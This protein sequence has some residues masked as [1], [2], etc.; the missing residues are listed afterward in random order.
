MPHNRMA[1]LG[2][3]GVLSSSLLVTRLPAV[4]N[5][6]NVAGSLAIERNR[7]TA[8]VLANGR[9]LV[10][11]GLVSGPLIATASAELYD[12]G[13][14]RGAPRAAWVRRARGTRPPC[15]PAAAF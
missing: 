3:S 11:G 1:I 13:P 14:S 7:H 10:A 5:A 4:A 12:P 6:W 8:T 2:I 15:S 9:V